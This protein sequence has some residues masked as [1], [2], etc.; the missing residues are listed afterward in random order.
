MKEVYSIDKDV[1]FKEIRPNGAERFLSLDVFRGITI[2]LMIIVNSPGKGAQ[3]YPYLV[4]AKWL[5]FT[6]ADLVF[7]SF[8]FAVGNAMSFSMNKLEAGG[9][10]DFFKKVVKRT[11]LVFL[12][13][14][15]MYWFPFF[16]QL[17]DGSWVFK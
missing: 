12:I 8:L 4:H 3:L 13:G 17:L 2:C 15:L 6:L 11:F 14:Y 16:K 9:N 7:P 5:G 10:S 1:V